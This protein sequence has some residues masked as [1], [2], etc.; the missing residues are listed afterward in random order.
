MDFLYQKV[1]FGLRLKFESTSILAFYPQS[2]GPDITYLEMIKKFKP[3]YLK[4]LQSYEAETWSSQIEHRFSKNGVTIV[5]YEDKGRFHYTI[6][7]SIAIA[8]IQASCK[9]AI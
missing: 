3:L 1:H 4:Y 6:N 5:Y 8:V 7:T 9:V 2:K